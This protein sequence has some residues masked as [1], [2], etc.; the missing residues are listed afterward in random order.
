MARRDFSWFLRRLEPADVLQVP[1]YLH[2]E[3]TLHLPQ[4]LP[5]DTLKMIAG[6]NDE[7]TYDQDISEEFTKAKSTE[8]A[9]IY[10]HWRAGSLPLTPSTYKVISLSLETERVMFSLMDDQTGEMF[11]AWIDRPH[12]YITG[13][14][15][16]YKSQNLMP[17]SIVELVS[18][19][20]PAVVRIRPQKKRTN[21][22]WLK[23]LLDWCRWRDR[24]STP[25]AASICRVR[26]TNGHLPSRMNKHLMTYG[27]NERIRK[28]I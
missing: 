22:E 26:R 3:T 21:K 1:L 17:G 19:N 5:E 6:L 20:D 25:S 16:W 27:K 8:I 28:L 14:R 7:L 18:T 12:F 4:D 13:L 2:S 9:L 15:N 11:K 10:P 24:V 23:T